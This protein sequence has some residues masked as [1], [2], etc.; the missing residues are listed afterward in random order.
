MRDMCR[1]LV[2][3]HGDLRAGWASMMQDGVGGQRHF[4]MT[5]DEFINTVKGLGFSKRHAHI[6]LDAVDVDRSRSVNLKEFMY[7]ENYGE[8]KG[9]KEKPSGSPPR[10]A[11]LL[12]TQAATGTGTER[13]RKGPDIGGWEAVADS[14][15]PKRPP[16]PAAGDG[17]SN[18]GSPKTPDAER[19]DEFVVLMTK[20][21][22]NEYLRRRRARAFKAACGP[23]RGPEGKQTPN[24]T[25]DGFSQPNIVA[26]VPFRFG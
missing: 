15:A 16:K 4:R 11:D 10:L 1:V 22:Y 3:R 17:Q 26:D 20:A 2:E 14:R 21:E 5:A 23:G 6:I 8:K 25:R 12:E 13:D 24:R 18:A 9:S 19:S 7:L